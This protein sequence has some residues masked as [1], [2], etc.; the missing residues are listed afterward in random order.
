MKQKLRNL[1]IAVFGAIAIT[2]ASAVLFCLFSIPKMIREYKE[3]GQESHD[4]GLGALSALIGR[5]LTIF[6]IGL[7]LFTIVYLI[8]HTKNLWKK[9]QNALSEETYAL[10]W[11]YTV[12]EA[13]TLLIYAMLYAMLS[14]LAG[15]F[16][17]SDAHLMAE[18][19]LWFFICLVAAVCTVIAL[20][21]SFREKRY[22]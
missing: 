13:S 22:E 6:G 9:L 19:L 3:L 21:I 2:G 4:E 8:F 15:T 12:S 14:G 10:Y 16:D 20:I 11:K 1:S 17:I 18:I 5:P 7:M